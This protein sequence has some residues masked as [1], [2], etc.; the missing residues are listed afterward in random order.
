[1]R[2]APLWLLIAFCGL[3]SVAQEP[4][5]KKELPVIHGAPASPA[6]RATA[7]PED[8]DRTPFTEEEL[9]SEGEFNIVA[10]KTVTTILNDSKVRDTL[11]RLGRYRRIGKTSRYYYYSFQGRM[12]ESPETIGGG[13]Y[14]H[15]LLKKNIVERAADGQI[16]LIV[17][18]PNPEYYFR[19]FYQPGALEPAERVTVF[20]KKDEDP[21]AV[22]EAT[23]P[24]K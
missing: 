8:E 3:V 1:L 17:D 6:P 13:A 23:K 5:G 16:S 21:T 11:K 4:T 19:V 22:P 15:L 14:W 10:A 18:S 2:R 9:S 7:V 24:A 12:E 20:L